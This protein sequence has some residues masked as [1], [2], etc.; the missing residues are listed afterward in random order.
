M[1]R[2]R[3]P[4]S[5]LF[6]LVATVVIVA[7]LYFAKA[8]LL[9]LAL[10]VLLSFLLTPLANRIERWGLPRVPSVLLVAGFSFAVIGLIIWIVSVQVIDL[11]LKLPTYIDRVTN[12]V[13]VITAGPGP[14]GKLV[15]TVKQIGQGIRGK[16]GTAEKPGE[17][18]A[19]DDAT[20]SDP[21]T[22]SV[23]KAPAPPG[24]PE[25][26][27]I[28]V[29]ARTS[30]LAQIRDWLGPLV[31][32][33]GSAGLVIVLVLFMLL[34]R[35]DQRNR[36]IELFGSG[37]MHVT[38]E[39]LTDAANR[40]TRYLR[41][42]FLIN[43]G[44]GLCVA[45]ALS[46]LEVPN[47]VMW[48]VLAFML[49][50]LPYIGPILAAAMPIAVSAAVS[51][52]WTQPLLVVG[53]FVV[54]ELVVN[55][56]I[57]PWMYGSTI[58]VSAVGIIVAAIFWTWL[59]GPIGLVLAM[60]LT[61]CL[62]VMARYV[63]QLRFV[64]VLLGDQPA[65]S[66][67]ERTYQRLLA[68]DDTEGRKLA[69][70]QMKTGSLT[71]YYDDVLIPALMLAERDRHAGTLSDEQESFIE[72]TAEDLVE[73]L[74]TAATPGAAADA[75]VDAAAEQKT[76]ADR[77]PARVLCIPLRDK[78]DQTCTR[79]L[80]QVL[81]AEGFHVDVGSVESLT[82]ELVEEVEKLDSE[83]VIVSI[84]PPCSPRNSRLLCRRLQSRFPNLPV[85]VGYWN[86]VRG[87]N[88]QQRFELNE[89]GRLVTSLAE[90]VA[91][92]RNEAARLPS[93][94]GMQHSLAVRAGDAADPKPQHAATVNAGD[95]A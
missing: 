58:G 79:M 60:P 1:P 93:T 38:T 57:E 49:R 33:L 50:F 3:N 21:L 27:E 73:E 76:I 9:P 6:V 48:G 95:A 8:V 4:S 47:A 25:P 35:E 30:P 2:T 12:K 94:E 36:L 17:P 7:A 37:N 59:W 71:A 69:K 84:L 44:Y 74:G 65:L 64:T 26:V 61:V 28:A 54:L 11:S 20:T 70:Q 62:V 10:A 87:E 43:A 18:P 22:P 34:K 82:N 31:A 23:A 46:V 66:L 91:A 55:N 77:P 13:E 90:A 81:A 78:A 80:G 16:N 42:Q 15:R 29:V 63:P 24:K 88:L 32:P 68:M 51:N 41:M 83:V 39:A 45:A 14:I 92:V 19:V 53:W 67:A 56:L 5:P 86:A 89:P 75:A 52:G 40:V 85:I 72:E